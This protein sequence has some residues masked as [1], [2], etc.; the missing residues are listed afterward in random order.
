MELSEFKAWLEGFEEAIDGTPTPEQ[1]GKIKSKLDEVR[2]PA[3]ITRPDTFL[4]SPTRVYSTT[5]HDLGSS[6]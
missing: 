2:Q 4:G 6:D 1:W 3:P 5:G